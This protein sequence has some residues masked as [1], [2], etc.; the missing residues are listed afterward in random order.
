MKSLEVYISLYNKKG[1][2]WAFQPNVNKTKRLQFT[3]AGFAPAARQ[4]LL[5]QTHSSPFIDSDLCFSYNVLQQRRLQFHIETQIQIHEI[6]GVSVNLNLC[7]LFPNQPI[8]EKEKKIM[9]KLLT[10]F[11]LVL[12]TSIVLAACG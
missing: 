5:T 3:G 6:G 10:L 7:R 1:Q 4:T 11:S 12:L 9:R 8:R 2:V